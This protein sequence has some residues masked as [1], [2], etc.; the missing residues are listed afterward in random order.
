VELSLWPHGIIAEKSSLV[1]ERKPYVEKSKEMPI[2]ETGLVAWQEI[3]IA[4]TLL[5]Q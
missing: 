3:R 5:N 1:R 2:K 4:A